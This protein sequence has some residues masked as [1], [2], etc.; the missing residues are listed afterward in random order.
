MKLVK[1]QEKG[2]GVITTTDEY[3]HVAHSVDDTTTLQQC[4][5]LYSLNIASMIIIM[6]FL[7]FLTQIIMENCFKL[8]TR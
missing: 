6:I 2:I 4:R 5:L 1:M 8:S 3:V 7:I